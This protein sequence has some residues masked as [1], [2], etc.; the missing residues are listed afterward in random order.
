MKLI[1]FINSLRESDFYIEHIY[2]QGGC[3]QFYLILSKMYKGCIPYISKRKNHIITRYKGK[4]YDIYGEVKCIEG[5]T[6]LTND[7]LIMVSEWS[8]AKN[9]LLMLKECPH[10]EEPLIFEK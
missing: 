10:C 5:Y 4:Y 7:E 3:Y 9:N 8:F 6:K 2:T 1:D